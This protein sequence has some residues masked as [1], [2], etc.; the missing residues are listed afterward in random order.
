[1]YAYTKKYSLS[2]YHISGAMLGIRDKFVKVLV[3]DQDTSL[4]LP[5]S[6]TRHTLGNKNN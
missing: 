5:T 6:L 2:I 3:K 4:S 1:M